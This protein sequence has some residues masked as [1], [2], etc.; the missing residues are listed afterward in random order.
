MDARGAIHQKRAVLSAL[1]DPRTRIVSLTIT[2]G[3]YEPSGLRPEDG[4]E[5]FALIAEGL[6]RRRRSGVPGFTVMSCDNVPANGTVARA[7]TLRAASHDR[8]LARWI[9][10]CV[11]FPSSVVEMIQGMLGEPEGGWPPEFQRIACCSRR[12][13]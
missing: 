7:A 5:V 13:A 9:E 2:G 3:A 11:S 10:S 12:I 6:D 8:G 4:P 1:S